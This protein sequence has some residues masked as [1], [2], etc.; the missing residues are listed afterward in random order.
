LL[1]EGGDFRFRR[2][3]GS[4]FRLQFHPADLRDDASLDYARSSAWIAGC[5]ALH[6]HFADRAIHD[7]AERAWL[8]AFL[9]GWLARMPLSVMSEAAE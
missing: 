5:A 7:V 1:A 8:K 2:S 9:D 4:R 3:V 6:H